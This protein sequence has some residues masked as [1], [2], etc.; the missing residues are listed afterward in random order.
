MLRNYYT[1]N[2]LVKE[3]RGITGYTV[4]EVFSQEKEC[5]IVR[6]SSFDDEKFIEFRA[7]GKYDSMHIKSRFARSK[8]NSID[9]LDFLLDETLQNVQLFENNR[10]IR[11]EF[12]NTTVYYQLFGGL[13]TN[14]ILVNNKQII[15]D[16]LKDSKNLT[17]SI[18]EVPT[19]QIKFYNELDESTGFVD[20]LSKSEFMLGRKYAEVF[21]QKYNYSTNSAIGTQKNKIYDDACDFQQ[22]L[23]NANKFYVYRISEYE[24]LLS[25]SELKTKYLAKE[26]FDSCSAALNRR[27]SLSYF[28]DSIK[29][30]KKSILQKVNSEL[31]KVNKKLTLY[32][33]ESQFIERINKYRLYGELLISLPDV[34]QRLL[35][36][37]ILTDYEGND[38]EI[39]LD[40]KLNL[41]ENSN[42]YFDKS[43]S[44]T[45]ELK[46][47]K[48]ILPDLREKQIFLSDILAKTNESENIKELLKFKELLKMDT[49]IRF[50][51]DTVKPEEKF[52]KFDLEEGYTLYVGKNAANNDELTMKFAK[53]NDWWFHSRGTSGSHCVLKSNSSEKPPK[54]ILEKAGAVAAYYSSAKNAKYTPV[55]Y[56]QKKYIR[57]PK[58][59]NVGSV[60]ISKE[61]VIMV[62]PGLP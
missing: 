28:I 4:T 6:L 39:P 20:A 51:G 59:A 23:L 9:L 24:V 19:P 42:K 37:I 33:D 57:K 2:S 21:A 5:I 17:G 26:E 11:F 29:D 16:S 13:N 56:T 47:M 10:V 15:I 55:A 41:A 14:L 25:L 34:K 61:I 48:E 18:Y 12:I 60:V 36:F 31:N 54:N 50:Q 1:L 43:R 40:P 58:G 30:V 52:R 38:I 45:K 62:T 7:D 8:S 3:I 27:L 22:E 46:I 35:N 53:A 32:T 44:Q 49:N